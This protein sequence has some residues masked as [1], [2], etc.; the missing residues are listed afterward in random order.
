[1]PVSQCLK[2]SFAVTAVLWAVFAINLILPI[3]LLNYGIVPRRISGLIGIV[4]SPFLH[5][6]LWHLV[7]NTSAF[8]V[9]LTLT[10][11]LGGRQ[12]AVALTVIVLVGGLG[13]WLVGGTAVHV[14]A[15][16]VIYGLIGFLILYGVLARRWKA[17]AAS[18]LVL[19]L[20][21]G[22]LFTL[23]A[24]RPGVSMSGHICGFLSGLLAAKLAANLA[25]PTDE[26]E[27]PA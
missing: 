9:L 21:S 4:A 17:L 6:G 27:T 16:G 11:S 7:A 13:V 20:Y 24:P 23:L 1:M 26:P 22:A 15:S 10:L 12:A 18:I 14:G 25:V 5:A 19:F 8:F 2:I 3:D